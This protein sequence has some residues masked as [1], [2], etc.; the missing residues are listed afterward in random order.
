[1]CGILG[2]N[3]F[4][5]IGEV[6]NGLTS[7][8]HRG[9]DGNT[10]FEFKTN[11]GYMYMTHNRLSIQDLSESANQPLIS[12]D[13][14]YYLAFNGEL[15][16]STFEKF[17]KSLREKYEFKTD[18]SDSELLLYFLIEYKDNLTEMLNEIEG[19]FSFAL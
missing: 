19:M 6:E 8:F 15:W 12:S 18:S 4:G 2:G 16:K 5:D 10:I 3:I 13:G 17:D 9:T 1:M 14:R 7:M 11:D